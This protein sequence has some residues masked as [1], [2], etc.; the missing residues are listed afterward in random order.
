MSLRD[1]CTDSGLSVGG[2]YAYIKNKD[3]LTHLIQSHG[4]I[5]TRRTMLAHTRDVP[6]TPD[7]LFAAVRAHLY[8]SE[9]MPAWF[10][11]SFM[12][13]KR[14]EERRVGTECVSPCRYRGL[15][16]HSKKK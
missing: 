5:L 11:F 3:D 1:L 16:Y 14:S 2:L 12:E 6:Y 4:F 15:P 7:K 13:A 10:R 8:L 9:L